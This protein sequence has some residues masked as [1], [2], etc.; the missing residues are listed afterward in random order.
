MD[1][2]LKKR[3]LDSI[4]LFDDAY[5]AYKIGQSLF[6]E[7]DDRIHNEFVYA[8]RAKNTLLR[9]IIQSDYGIDFRLSLNDLEQAARHILNDCFDVALYFA[10][11]ETKSISGLSKRISISS[12]F[13]DYHKVAALINEFVIK[14]AETRKKR[15]GAR[16]QEYLE[17]VKSENYKSL[18][19]YC[20]ALP[21]I[22]ND[23]IIARE[24]DIRKSR[25][26]LWVIVTSIVFGFA[27]VVTQLVSSLIANP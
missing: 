5:E 14:V 1:A 16:I 8:S 17:L 23:F 19:S 12:V 9:C 25:R 20:L 10:I 21:T 6:V 18:I 27:G 2:D 13:S 4:E 24:D 11:N 7:I 15:G 3:L 26:F 22:K